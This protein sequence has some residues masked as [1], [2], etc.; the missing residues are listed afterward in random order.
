M[1]GGL[2][3][4]LYIGHCNESHNCQRKAIGEDLHIHAL[5]EHSRRAIDEE[6]AAADQEGDNAKNFSL[7]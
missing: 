3:P 1:C 7:Q 2:K 4:S 5:Q 6:F